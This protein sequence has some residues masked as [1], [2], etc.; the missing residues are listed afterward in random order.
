MVYT[1]TGAIGA[2]WVFCHQYG[3]ER[4]AKATLNPGSV[5]SFKSW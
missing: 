4:R 5:E 2:G 1:Y 3:Y